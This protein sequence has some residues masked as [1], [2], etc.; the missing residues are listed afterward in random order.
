MPLHYFY[1]SKRKFSNSLR[2]T[3]LYNAEIFDEY[4]E[5][6]HRAKFNKIKIKKHEKQNFP[7][8]ILYC[9]HLFVT[10]YIEKKCGKMNVKMQIL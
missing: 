4:D 7:F 2:K 8:F 3:L 9:A 5:V 1:S 6:L 10:L